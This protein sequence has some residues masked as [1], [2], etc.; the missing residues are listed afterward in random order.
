MISEI[1]IKGFQSHKETTLQLVDGVNAL[2]GDTDSGKSAVIKALLWLFTNRPVLAWEDYKSYWADETEVAVRLDDANAYVGRVKN[3]D[4]SFYYIEKDD[5]KPQEF[6]AFGKGG[7]PQEV[8]D[9]LC[10][11]D[12]N[13]QSQMS[14]PFMLS[15]TSGAVGRFLNDA[16]DLEIIDRATSNIKSTLSKEK[17]ELETAKTDQERLTE[18]KKKY[19]WL[20]E[21]EEKLVGLEKQDKQLEVLDRK[22]DQ[23]EELMK[24]L[25]SLQIEIEPLYLVLD[26]K[27]EIGRLGGEREEIE[28]DWAK[29][30]G[31]ENLYSEIEECEENIALLSDVLRGQDEVDRLIIVRQQTEGLRKQYDNLKNLFSDILVSQQEKEKEEKELKALEDRF[32]KAF[33]TVCPLCGK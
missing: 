10:L 30:N 8:L 25:T 6:R 4:D 12:V 1:Y 14:L 28:K 16:A 3:K 11:S 23:I 22:I 2:T 19:A 27:E 5:Q 24:A 29:L 20:P 32:H 13:Y 21:A 7:P 26:S 31:L 18:N 17:G 9:L 15:Q 33:P